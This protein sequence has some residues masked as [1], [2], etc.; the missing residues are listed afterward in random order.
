VGA[1]PTEEAFAESGRL[2]AAAASPV[3]DVRG[4]VEY[5]R[6]MVEVYVRRGLAHALET[7]GAA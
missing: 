5:K 7:A 4:S 2:A 1:A 3:A 6:H